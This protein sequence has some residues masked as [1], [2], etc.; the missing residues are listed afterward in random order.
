MRYSLSAP[1]ALL[2]GLGLVQP[3]LASD[4]MP[5]GAAKPFQLTR[6]ARAAAPGLHIKL[7]DP[8]GTLTYPV[9][10][11]VEY[12][13]GSPVR[14]LATA[15]GL[16]VP[17]AAGRTVRAVTLGDSQRFELDASRVNFLVFSR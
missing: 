13:S 3:A 5:S 12:D 17:A 1:I 16:T 6:S 2:I 4:P 8:A 14:A 15:E 7:V 9:P 10:V 11:A